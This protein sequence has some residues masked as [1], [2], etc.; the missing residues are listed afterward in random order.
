[1]ALALGAF[2]A[3]GIVSLANLESS[4]DKLRPQRIAQEPEAVAAGDWRVDKANSRLAIQV[5]Q[6]KTPVDGTFERWK[7]RIKLDPQN[8]DRAR[9]EVDVDISSLALGGVSEDAKSDKFLN[10]ATFPNARFVASD[11]VKTGDDSFAAR[12]MLTLAGQ[13]RPLT[14]P[15]T[16]TIKND[17]ASARAEV[18]LDRLAF[19]V[20]KAGFPGGSLVGI[21]VKVEVT[22]RGRSRSLEHC[23]SF[24][25][26]PGNNPWSGCL[27]N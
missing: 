10:V 16:L 23:R 4:T 20:G 19:G 7:A 12:G 24:I 8:L 21:E 1:M 27:S 25:A 26:G 6:S 15:F 13:T 5:M 9:I 17:R 22:V 11:I 18:A 3:I 14:L 2:A